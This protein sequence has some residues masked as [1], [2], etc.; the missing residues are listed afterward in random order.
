MGGR[1]K[2]PVLIVLTAVFILIISVGVA[3]A[4]I[5][6]S[7]H[8]FS[9]LGASN[10]TSTNED[11]VCIFCHTPHGAS[12]APLWNRTLDAAG[13]TMY[14]SPT[15]NA[16]PKPTAP[17]GVSLLCMSCHDGVSA[18][19]V[20]VNY[21]VNNPILMSPNAIGDLSYPPWS[22]PNLTKDLANDHPVSF[23]FDAA[24]ISADAAGGPAKLQLPISTDPIKLF[25]S[26]LECASCHDPHEEGSLAA[27]TVPFL[28]KSNQASGMCLTCHIK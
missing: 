10:F 7:S 3:S 18:I 5:V 2:R 20:V 28:R 12:A 11:Q 8:D 4:T 23:V 14:D 9:L 19:N 1:T 25:N 13:Y 26:K 16:S 17:T 22:D 27:G 15:F 6:G 24:L 21:A